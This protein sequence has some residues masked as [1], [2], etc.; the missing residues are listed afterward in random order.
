MS[1]LPNWAKWIWWL[2]LVGI[3]TAFLFSRYPSLVTGDASTVN[4]IAFLVW[5]ALL[6]A[7]LFSEVSV[8]GISVKQEIA[9]V[10]RQ[11]GEIRNDIKNA[12]DV[13][14]TISTQINIPPPVSDAELPQLEDKIIA[15]VS[16]ALQ[17]QGMPAKT[18]EITN[19]SPPP[20]ASL[21]FS[22]RY[23]IE[24]EIRRIAVGREIQV[25]GRAPTPM[26]VL[27]LL[28]QTEVIERSL[29]KAVRD[30]YAVCSRGVHAE[31]VTKAQLDFVR[32]VGPRVIAALA[33]IT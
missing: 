23:Q 31:L 33:A 26:T 22:V 21:V 5:I 4:V 18:I 6:L 19:L 17:A 14:N 10:K 8:L 32:D 25:G 2:F 16:K 12:V 30:L 9:E 24:K 11:I 1:K 27:R 28:T 20:E 13:R 29:E 15:A 3:I 7:P